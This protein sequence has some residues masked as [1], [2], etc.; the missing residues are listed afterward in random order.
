MPASQIDTFLGAIRAIES[1]GGDPKGDYSARGPRIKSGQYAGQRAYGAYQIMPGNWAAWSREA[2]VPGADIRDP[3]MQDVV[4]RH[5]MLGM[6]RRYGRWDYVGGEW[7]AGQ[8]GLNKFLNGRGDAS[9]GNLRVSQYMKRVRTNMER[10]GGGPQNQDSL[11][12]AAR[13]G[14]GSGDVNPNMLVGAG[15]SFDISLQ[16]QEL[17][18][19]QPQPD[20]S[21]SSSDLMEN[22]FA[23]LSA[24]IRGPEEDP[25]AQLDEEGALNTEHTLADDPSTLLEGD[26]NDPFQRRDE[27]GGALADA[28]VM[29]MGTG[30]NSSLGEYTD[31]QSLE[32]LPPVM[33]DADRAAM[34]SGEGGGEGG[35]HRALQIGEQYLGTP[36]LWGGTDPN[37]GFDCS[38]LVQHVFRQMGV[39]LPRVSADQSNA[40]VAVANMNEARP[41]DLV[42][43]RGQNGRPNHI[44]IYA[45]NG[46]MLEAPRTGLNVRYRKIGRTPDKIRRVTNG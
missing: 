30:V 8:G 31:D 28:G 46:V 14:A 11:A 40:G 27:I 4:A 22:M 18:Q 13:S 21:L 35:G 23:R 33:S 25:A 45:G 34:L 39:N 37:K 9:D 7:F 16:D 3:K 20:A 10:F 2:G 43:W 24:R 36:Y 32:N 38:G 17:A 42:F 29:L 41:G 5:K 26:G 1:G 12:H 19:S 6:Y 44:G 15:R